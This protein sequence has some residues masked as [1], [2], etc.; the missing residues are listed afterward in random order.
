MVYVI[1]FDE[2]LIVGFGGLWFLRAPAFSQ[3]PVDSGEAVRNLFMRPHPAP[4]DDQ[5]GNDNTHH[6]EN[7]DNTE[8]SDKKGSIIHHL[9]PDG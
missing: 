3:R 6:H 1:W 2:L 7:V 4:E 5:H 8:Q 9:T